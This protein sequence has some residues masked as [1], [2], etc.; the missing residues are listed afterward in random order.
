M[1]QLDPATETPDQRDI[2]LNKDIAAFSYVWIM[3]IVIFV[4]RKE[5]AFVRFH[6]R[7]GIVLFLFS[8]ILPF[9]PFIGK[10][11]MLLTVAG[12]I[13]GFIHAAQGQSQDVPFIGKLSRGE[14]TLK[15]IADVLSSF[16]RALRGFFRR[17]APAS[18]DTNTPSPAAPLDKTP[19]PPVP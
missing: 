12:M 2:R 19:P 8:I 6:A 4:A 11:L 17:K 5:S 10:L 7:Q 15:E 16:M 3:S 1:N 14:L 9:I 13:I 18:K